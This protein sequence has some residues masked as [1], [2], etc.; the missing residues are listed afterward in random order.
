[1]MDLIVSWLCSAIAEAMEWVIETLCSAFGYDISTFN[2]TFNFAATAYDVILN[3]ALP[4]ALLLAAWSLIM[5]FWKGADKAPSTPIRTVINL[6][7][8]IAFIYYGNNLF[9][10][11]LDFCQYPYDALLGKDAATW[12]VPIKG[13]FSKTGFVA[14]AF[15]GVSSLVYLIMLLMIGISF[16]K[17]LL[18]IVERYV[19]TFVLMYLSP[20]AAA[21]LASSTTSGIYKKFFTMFV[22]QCV[23]IFLNAW[24]LKMAVSGLSLSSS[25]NPV[26]ISLLLCFAFLKVAARMDSYLNQI[27]LNSAITGGG[28]GAEI[29]G[30]GAAMFNRGGNGG[31][32][33]TGAGGAG[34]KILGASKSV[35][36]WTNRYAPLGA[37]CKAATDAAVGGVKGTSEAF[38]SGA[39]GN[40]KGFRS[41]AGAAG[42]GLWEGVKSGLRHSDNGFSNIVENTNTREQI[43]N[44]KAGKAF[45]AG[46]D[47][48]NDA[49]NRIRDENTHPELNPILTKIPDAPHIAPPKAG[50]T[51]REEDNAIAML[52]PTDK[53]LA[54]V[55]GSESRANSIFKQAQKENYFNENWTDS[56]SVSSVMEGLGLDKHSKEVADCIQAGYG[57]DGAQNI[58]FSLTSKGIHAQYDINGYRHKTDVVDSA[59]FK[60]LSK[61]E[62][63][64]FEKSNGSNY[65]VRS[66]K[67]QFEKPQPADTEK[68]N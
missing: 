63:A 20:L 24:C 41:K 5:F 38:R 14:N 62:Q 32:G 26:I 19:V 9:E 35:G 42:K 67:T 53:T 13:I 60:K 11:I 17:L 48:V 22:S 16:I 36:T 66:T 21:T 25:D 34:S 55:S 1:M 30:A 56:R 52:Q 68:N 43:A 49:K 31:G 65:Y 7:V 39:V 44:T 64:G 59:Q 33:G 28:M 2:K 58:D 12:G 45:D 47:K 37:A 40:A 10:A 18:E 50:Y 46:I 23:L 6:V 8:A 3:V 51:H 27:G 4:L 15:A 61:Q 57:R 29:M 54:E